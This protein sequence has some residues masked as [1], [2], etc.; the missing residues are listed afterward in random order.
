MTSFRPQWVFLRLK[1]KS[2]QKFNKVKTSAT[3]VA[4][5]AQEDDRTALFRMFLFSKFC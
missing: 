3:V 5:E 1:R 2:F 4:E